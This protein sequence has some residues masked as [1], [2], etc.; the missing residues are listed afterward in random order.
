MLSREQSCLQKFLF[1]RKA[2]KLLQGPSTPQS[3]LIAY[4]CTQWYICVCM[5]L[6]LSIVSHYAEATVDGC[7]NNV[8]GVI[9]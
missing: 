3:L 5:L 8:C 2:L 6:A 9:F 4:I 7:N 1:A